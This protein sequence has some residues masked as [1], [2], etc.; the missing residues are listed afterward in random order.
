MLLVV[1]IVIH[2]LDHVRQGRALNSELFGL[3]A[4]ALITAMV[5]LLL[6]SRG[7]RLAPVAAVIVGFG[8][9]IGI[10]LVHIA[11]HWGPLSDPYA[12]AHVDWFSWTVIFAMMLVAFMLG[13]T[14]LRA[15]WKSPSPRR[16]AISTG[17]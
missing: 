2:D 6:A 1:M 17:V 10:A 11:P 3:G 9:V 16:P 4:V 8:N 15:L 14:G 5:S 7:H 13:V 12:A